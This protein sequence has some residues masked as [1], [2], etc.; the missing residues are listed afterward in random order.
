MEI[1]GQWLSKGNHVTFAQLALSALGPSHSSS[2]PMQIHGVQ[3]F[4]EH[5]EPPGV[6]AARF[7][8]GG[9]PSMN[10]GQTQ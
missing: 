5:G 8:W 6:N 7:S 10:M 3:T 4:P 1:F 9:Q 2:F